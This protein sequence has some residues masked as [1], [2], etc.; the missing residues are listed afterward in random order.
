MGTGGSLPGGKAIG[1]FSLPHL[2]LVV[3][4]GMSAAIIPLPQ[5]TSRCVQRQFYV[6]FQPN[7]SN[8]GVEQRSNGA[9]ELIPIHGDNA[10]HSRLLSCTVVLIVYC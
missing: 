8:S 4:S 1:T 7:R 2:Y 6:H 10:L 5:T 3:K 9:V